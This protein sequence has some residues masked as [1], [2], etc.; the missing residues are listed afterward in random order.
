MKNEIVFLSEETFKQDL[1]NCLTIL[2]YPDYLTPYYVCEYI[3]S[4]LKK[5]IVKVQVIH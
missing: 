1:E 4:A 2:S 5:R 3:T